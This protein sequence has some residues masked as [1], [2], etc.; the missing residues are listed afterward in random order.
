MSISKILSVAAVSTALML[1]AVDVEAKR[2]GGGKSTGKQQS[3]TMQRDSTPAQPSA[4]AA[5]APSAPAAGAATAATASKAAPA[6]AAA[7]TRSKW[8]GPLM[9]LAAGL[10]LA[11][12]ASYLGFGEGFAMLMMAILAAVVLFAVIGFFMRRRAQQNSPALASASAGYTPTSY[13]PSADPVNQQATQRSAFNG[14]GSG[15]IKIG[16]GSLSAA[17]AGTATGAQAL[18]AGF[19]V[20]DFLRN[21]KTYFMRLQAANDSANSSDIREFTTPEMYGELMVDIQERNG[22]TQTTEVL[23]LNTAFMGIEQQGTQYVAAVRYTGTMREDAQSTTSFDEA[24]LL[25]KPV[26]GRSG[27]LLAGIEQL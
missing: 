7:S 27:W 12:L 14:I 9:G 16:G 18:P 13:A 4:P 10:G 19:E 15:G 2:L 22:A 25:V 17:A 23:S 11:A 20:N 5:S 3:S 1:T 21:A 8:A 24:W 26:D 6:A